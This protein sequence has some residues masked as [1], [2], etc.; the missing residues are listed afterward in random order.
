MNNRE[1]TTTDYLFQFVCNTLHYR[2]VKAY[3]FYLVLYLIALQ[4]VGRHLDVM[5]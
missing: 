5:E 2:E 4:T 3:L 1:S